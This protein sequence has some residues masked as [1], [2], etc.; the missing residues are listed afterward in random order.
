MGSISE[1]AI[2]CIRT[3]KAFSTETFETSRYAKRNNEAYKLGKTSGIYN[4]LFSF[5]IGFMMNG[6]NA[7]II[8]YGAILAK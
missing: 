5:F 4:G 2:A 6:V 1:E 7:L 3:V 8:Y